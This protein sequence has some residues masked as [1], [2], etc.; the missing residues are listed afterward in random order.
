MFHTC[1]P[2]GRLFYWLLAVMLFPTM[3]QATPATTRIADVIYRADGAPAGGVLLISWPAF[4][5][6]DGA[7]VGAGTQ[8][9][10]LGP[11]GTLSVNLVPNVGA[12]PAS[13]LYTVVFQLDD[14][15]AKTEYWLVPA[16]TTATVAAVR[17]LPGAT[18]SASQM[19]TRQYVDAAVAAKASD[20]SVVHTSGAETISGSKQ[21]AAAPSVPNPLQPADAVNKAYVDTALATVGA[22]S[23]VS[24]TGDAMSGPLML[25]GDP[26]APNHASTRH[27]VDIGLAGKADV[28][29]GLIPAGELGG[30]SADGSKCLLGNNT[31]GPCGGSSNAVSIQNVAVAAQA[32]TDG[33]VITYEAASGSYKPKAGS[34]LSAGMQAVKY[35]TDFVWTQS[36]ATDL[37]TAGAKTL[38]LSSCPAGVRGAEAEYWIYIAGTGTAE[39]V[40]VTGGTCNGDGQPGTLQFTTANS[41]SSGYTVSSASGGLQ[42][43]LIAARWVPSGATASQGGRVI[44]PPGEFNAYARVSVRSSGITLDFSGSVINCYMADTCL[45]VGDTANS[46]AFFDVTV[47]NPR[48]RPMVVGTAATEKPFIEVNAQKTR[49][50]NVETR[51]PATGAY[52]STYVQVDDDQAFL[53]DGL[54]TSLGAGPGNY[55]VRCDT[56]ACNP[57][58]YAPGPFNVYSAVGWLKHLNIGLQGHGNG[59][60]WQSGNTIRISDSVIQG[61]SQY[62][63]RCGTRRGGYGGCELENVYEEDGANANPLGNLGA[64]GVIAQ[65]NNVRIH[66]GIGPAAGFPS[67]AN[68]G[69]ND[70]RY[71]IVAHHAT[72][73][74]SNPLYLGSA[75]S[76]GSG[77]ITVLMPDIAGASSFDLLRVPGPTGGNR[78]QGPF[79]TGN[80][81]VAVGVSRATACSNGVC[82]FTDTNATPASYTVVA[83]NGPY[84][85]LLTLW[86]GN[87]VLGS[88]QDSASVVVGARAFLD[89]MINGVVAETGSLIPAVEAQTCATVYSWTPM[90]VSCL[91]T[92]NPYNAVFDQPATIMVSKPNADAGVKTNLKGRLNFMSLGT[93]PGHIITLSDS[94]LQKTVATAG[95]RPTNDVNDA[96]IGLDQGDGGVNNVG[97]SLGAP[98]SISSYIGNAGDGT[99]WLERLTAS[100]KTFKTNVTIQGNLTVT[101]TCTGCGGGGSITLKTNGV[102][103]GSQSILNLKSGSNVTLTD[104]GSGG[105]TIASSGGS[106]GVTSVF[107]RTGI[108]TAANGDYNFNQ[109]AGS[110][111]SGQDYATGVAASTYPKVTV[112]AQ[113]RVTAGSALSA[114]DI[115]AIPE[116]G[117]TN[118]AAD[119]AAKLGSTGPQTFSGDLTVSGTVYANAFQSTGSGPWSVEGAFGTL[120]AV[121]SSKSKLGFGPNGKL[122]VSEN[123]GAVTE[124]A[125]KVPQQFTYTFFDPNN[126]LSMSLQVPSVYVNRATALHVVEVYCEI[127][128][129][130]ATINLQNNGAN[131]LSADLACSTSGAVSSTF[132]SGKDAIA[133]GAKVGH[134]TTALGTGLHRLNVVVKFTVD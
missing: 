49:I 67:F 3:L 30:G 62:G 91:G 1:R 124:V 72:Y 126:P 93:G 118:L 38:N 53:L 16:T 101:G 31:W 15:T 123:S 6:A 47:M 100:A 43:A 75:L 122:S 98:K 95:N 52:F 10:T 11:G 114:S 71:Y 87:L 116:S 109:L 121:G 105:I 57:I 76:N 108:V 120:T 7:A 129:G 18:S 88:N 17:T 20:A 60:D 82:T 4:T 21:F 99:N 63:V 83:S 127:D 29:N 27:Y 61:F 92:S 77:N 32:P 39:A 28:I 36:P 85:P 44:A 74:A 48:G 111:A 34:G 19:A 125:K 79:G 78:E 117:V 133:V 42:E 119:L 65:G 89:T 8:S 13:T 134:V 50:F 54:D 58:V 80:F 130:T 64:A 33:Q 104:D 112:N 84:M 68:T 73:G 102:N 59:V 45:F 56:T 96:Y 37:S 86:P 66:G 5:S 128:T 110:L 103:N 131:I 40:K 46:I 55:G 51:V 14:G 69:T 81:G 2:A 132:A 41:H 94:N 107:G 35:A 97:I 9:V 106:G 22:G 115:P 25:S 23:Y 24:K 90:V 26:T 113:G 70:Y 12:N